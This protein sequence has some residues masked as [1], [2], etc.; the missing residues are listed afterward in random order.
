MASVT[1]WGD[2]PSDRHVSHHAFR[3]SDDLDEWLRG[4]CRDIAD[5]REDVVNDILLDELHLDALEVA[6]LPDDQCE[7]YEILSE[8]AEPRALVEYVCRGSM[9]DAFLLTVTEQYV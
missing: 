4:W 3:N 7:R 5:N 8:K 1:E 2:S 9:E 6:R